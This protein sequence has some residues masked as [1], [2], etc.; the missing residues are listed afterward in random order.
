MKKYVAKRILMIIPIVLVVSILIFSIM[1]FVPGDPARAILGVNATEVQLAEKRAELGLDQPFLVQLGTYL[2]N[3]FLKFD[4]GT[5][6]I[7]NKSVSSEILNRFPRT[8]LFAVMCMVLSAIVGIPLGMNAAIHQDGIGDRISMGISLIGI[9]LP[10]FWVALMLVIVF[11]LKLKL[12]PSYGIGGIQYYILP[13]IAGA[14]GGIAQV[15][16]LTRSSMLE[17]IRSDYVTTARAKGV[18]ERRILWR[19]I[20]P[21]GVIPVIQILGN[22]LGDSL[23]GAIVIENVFSIPGLGT[24][25]TTGI[26][27]RDYPV[28]RGVVVFLGLS[29]CIIMLIVDVAFAFADPRIKAQYEGNK[30]SKRR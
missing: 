24:Y 9:S 28:V 15:A 12:L 4:F 26:T 10:S 18:P 23:A 5:S 2:K 21:N 1:Y 8:L 13:C 20:F 19:H 7:Y 22:I 29:F 27:N 11:S 17:V 16:R 30:K 14:F 3:L 25:L 6:Y